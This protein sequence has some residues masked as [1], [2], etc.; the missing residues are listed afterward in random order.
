MPPAS[1]S[2][3]ARAVGLWERHCTLSPTLMS[4]QTFGQ[5]LPDQV[6]RIDALFDAHLHLL[7][8]VRDLYRDRAAAEREYAAKMHALTKR[9]IEKRSKLVAAFVVGDEPTKATSDAT[10]AQNTLNAAFDEIVESMSASAQDHVHL[11]DA[12]TTKVVDVLRAVERKQDEVK[13]KE[14]TFFQRLLTE[15]DRLYADRLKAKQKY[16]DECAEVE[17]VRQKQVRASD[18]RHAD[19]AAR[20]AE[21]QRADMLN[22]KNVYLISTAIANSVKVKFYNDDLPALEDQFR[23]LFYPP[24]SPDTT[25]LPEIL[26]SRLALRFAKILGHAQTI[27]LTHLDALKD[28]VVR[29]EKALGDVN[30]AKDQA[31][32]IEHNLRPF[33]VPGDWKFEPCAIYHDTD[34]MNIEPTPK[35]FL[36]NKL[37]RARA[38]LNE[39]DPVLVAKRRDQDQLLDVFMAYEA[40]SSL[41]DPADVGETYLDTNHQVIAYATSECVLNTEIAVIS[42]AIGDDEGDQRPH[43]FKSSSFSIPTQCGYCK[44]LVDMG[45]GEAGQDV[46]RLWAIGA[47]KMRAQG[48]SRLS[49]GAWTQYGQFDLE[50]RVADFPQRR[51][52]PVIHSRGAPG[53]AAIVPT[54]SAFAQSFAAEDT[55]TETTYQSARVVF[56][57]SPTSEFELAVAEGATVHVVEPDDGSGWVKVSDG[58][59]AGLVPASY[60]EYMDAAGSSTAPRSEEG[61]GEFVR[62]LYAYTAQGSDEIGLSE[63]EMV[64]LSSVGKQYGDG[65]WEGIN[66]DGDKG[67]FPSNYVELA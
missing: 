33:A 10:Y 41:G 5:A 43:S 8:E 40:D 7:V 42:A 67:I 58:Q 12:L 30:P 34:A 38:K 20:Q 54:P 64:E 13:K 32:F 44:A 50:E 17:I 16:D 1:C 61:S 56:D 3:T 31:L 9:A 24:T 27:Q 35:V 60:V 55:D 52:V 48:T 63:G 51:G 25:L 22:S 66:S 26:L 47:F 23:T 29:A 2:G 39:L 59:N 21:Q 14:M 49:C 15:R 18:D 19:R 45:P 57:F 4:A 6:E 62:A 46:P 53:G 28:R 11:A 37:S 65:W 36:Q